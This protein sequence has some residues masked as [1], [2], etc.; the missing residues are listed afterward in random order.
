MA[1]R[2]EVKCRHCGQALPDEAPLCPHCGR[3]LPPRRG[4]G[5]ATEDSYLM[6]VTANVLRLR[7]QWALAEAKISEVLRR[8]P[9]NA[10]AYSVLGDISRDR[11]EPADAIQWYKMALQYN[12][13]SSADRKKLEALID[14][15]FAR[16]GSGFVQEARGALGRGLDGLSAGVREARRSPPIALIVAVA[17]GLLLLIAIFALLVTGGQQR[18]PAPTPPERPS[19]AFEVA[20]PASP[21]ADQQ[22][23]EPAAPP[24]RALDLAA[25]D[26]ASREAELQERLRQRARELDPNA[27]LLSVQ[28]NPVQSTVSLHLSMPRWWSPQAT[29]R[30]ILRVATHLASAAAE[31]DPRLFSVEIRCDMRQRGMPD[32]LAMM[33]EV[34]PHQLANLEEEEEATAAG[35]ARFSSLWWHPDLRQQAPEEPGQGSG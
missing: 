13:S 17:L 5:A 21:S 1:G 25:D 8:D 30:D 26:L 31:W 11:G 7:R 20:S 2:T 27:R 15:V 16:R 9:E 19:G 3:L 10:A 24:A 14:R 33:A 22:E 23:A 29:R 18:A 35:E 34:K 4:N 12:P 6:L 32:R 28:I